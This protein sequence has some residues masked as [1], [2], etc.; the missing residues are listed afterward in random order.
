MADFR[1]EYD[2]KYDPK[3]EAALQGR[4]FSDAEKQKLLRIYNVI[5]HWFPKIKFRVSRESLQ[6]CIVKCAKIF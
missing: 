5:G 1:Q 6:R 4:R 2:E 3:A